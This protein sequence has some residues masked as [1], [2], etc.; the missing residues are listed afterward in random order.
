MSFLTFFT[1]CCCC[2]VLF[3][4]VLSNICAH[5]FQSTYRN[6]H[7]RQL[8]KRRCAVTEKTFHLLMMVCQTEQQGTCIHLQQAQAMLICLFAFFCFAEATDTVNMN[9]HLMTCYSY[10]AICAILDITSI[11]RSVCTHVCVCVYVCAHEHACACVC[12]AVPKVSALLHLHKVI[13]VKFIQPV[14]LCREILN[15][16]FTSRCF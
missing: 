14:S 13:T 10:E 15:L 6:S 8:C 5:K 1:F 2:F 4:T 7:A 12:G 9:T 16:L 3:V 11:N